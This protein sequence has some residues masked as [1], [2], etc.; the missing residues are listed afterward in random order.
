MSTD[1]ERDLVAIRKIIDEY[2]DGYNT[3]NLSKVMNLWTEDGVVM[4]SG[5]P[6]V[7]GKEAIEDWKGVYFK[8]Y[9]FNLQSISDE[10]QIGGD[11]A[12][13]RGTYRMVMTP[14]NGGAPVSETGKFIQIFRREPDG[15]WKI[16]RDM[17]NTSEP[18]PTE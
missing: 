9:N 15:S 2:R 14:R 12:F 13:N 1:V 4:P 16:A 7:I 10:V 5:E 3:G 11:W 17:G 6:Y 8:Q 18:P